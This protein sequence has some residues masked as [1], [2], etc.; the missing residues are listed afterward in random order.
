LA[1]RIC[2]KNGE[3]RIPAFTFAVVA[4]APDGIARL[5]R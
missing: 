2:P 5:T 3:V 4:R 1:F